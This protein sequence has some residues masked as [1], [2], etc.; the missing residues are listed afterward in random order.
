MFFLCFLGS[1]A[2]RI[3][4]E[5]KADSSF[6]ELD[7]TQYNFPSVGNDSLFIFSDIQN[8]I[9]DLRSNSFLSA[10][11]DSMIMMTDTTAIAYL[12]VGK[13]LVYGKINW[14][15]IEKE[16]LQD[17]RIRNIKFNKKGVSI[18]EMNYAM[19]IVRDQLDK[20]GYPLS[21]IY[22][23]NQYVRN[24]SLFADI[25]INKGK[26]IQYARIDILPDSLISK[27][28]IERFLDI[29]ENDVFD[30]EKVKEIPRQINTLPYLTMGKSPKVKIYED[31]AVLELPIKKRNASRF[32]FL[33]GVLPNV[34]NENRLTGSG[35]VTADLKNKFKQG[36]ELYF[37][38]R[39]LKPE[40]Q[41]IDIKVTYPFLFNLPFGI[42]S[43]FALY[44][45]GQESRDLN[46]EGGIEYRSSPYS[47]STFYTSYQSS[48]LINVDTVALFNSESLPVSLDIAL[49]NLGYRY[50]LD[51]RD[52]RFNP[53]K[54]LRI[55]AGITVGIKSI[56]RNNRITELRNE[57]VDFATAYD[58]LEL[59]VFQ[60]GSDLDIEYFI[61]LRKASTLLIANK[62]GA[63]YN[64]T[65]V[66]SNEY[67]RI[68]G[69]NILRGF[70]EE[71]IRAQYYSIFTAEFRYLLSL[72]SYF[73]TFIDYGFTYNEF[74]PSGK[75]DLPLGLGVGLSFQTTAGIFGIDVAL[76]REQNN[77]I[78]FRNTKTHFG[79]ISL[80]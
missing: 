48:R 71:S 62:S 38:F 50:E 60:F 69:S 32:D 70:D 7:T 35:E 33:I 15:G 68:G 51:K 30:L 58:T 3:D 52:Y 56:I 6:Y 34:E 72:N 21:E 9:L 20:Q 74:R 16:Y 29:Q 67:Y 12:Y 47:K 10:N 46:A 8:V 1:Q 78:D 44:R 40:T 13:P 31:K 43:Q 49:N 39:Q 28:F 63:K 75:W 76:G 55:N 57:S 53:R 37:Y 26:L 45:N 22:F 18:Q 11:L 41:R 24:D 2:Q 42:H 4:I 36:E 66:F 73:S 80:F 77:P 5:Y 65:Q 23:S 27:A 61:P 79:F 64:P 59:R 17:A 54:G 19:E 14:N 25:Q